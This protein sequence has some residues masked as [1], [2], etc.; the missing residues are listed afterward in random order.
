MQQ[1]NEDMDTN[2][3]NEL[4]KTDLDFVVLYED[5]REILIRL[6]KKMDCETENLESLGYSFDVGF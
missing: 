6:S 1:R 3:L 4:K 2:Y 5:E